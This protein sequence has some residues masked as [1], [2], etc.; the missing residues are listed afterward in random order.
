MIVRQLQAA[1]ADELRFYAKYHRNKV[2]WLLHTICVPLEWWSWLVLVCYI[3]RSRRQEVE[4]W[5]TALS[6]WHPNSLPPPPF[7][8]QLA[9]HLPRE[10]PWPF[11]LFPFDFPA[12][13]SLSTILACYYI[14]VRPHCCGIL[15]AVIQIVA[16]MGALLF[17]EAA[18]WEW[19]W[20][21]AILTQLVSWGLQ[22]GIGHWLIERNQ[23]GM[24]DQLTANSIVLCV[25]LAVDWGPSGE[26]DITGGRGSTRYPPKS[27]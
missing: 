9:E 5:S 17:G 16:A 25:L 13:V 3:A 21:W 7:L 27:R 14:V 11:A 1:Y 15:G 12:A 20:T 6:L 10:P 4:Q 19:A 18:G 22:V 26:M 23:P 2:N 24:A 8:P